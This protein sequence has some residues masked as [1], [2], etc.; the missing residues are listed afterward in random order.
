LGPPA[1][2]ECCLD[3]LGAR[4]GCGRRETDEQHTDFGTIIRD[5]LSGQY[6]YPVGIVAFSAIEGCSRDA[7]SEV[8]DEL[9][10]RAADAEITPPCG[11]S[12][13]RMLPSPLPSN[14]HFHYAE[15]LEHG[16]P[17]PAERISRATTRHD[18]IADYLTRERD[19]AETIDRLIRILDRD[20][21]REAIAEVLVDARVQPRPR[22]EPRRLTDE[23]RRLRRHR[24]VM[25]RPPRPLLG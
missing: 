22:T 9:A 17:R 20:S 1:E 4:A 6:A 3:D 7:T 5:L 11:P 13:K 16:A 2:P 25:R 10:E 19:A 23:L 12:S 24:L 15:L 21:L 14:S 18:G 8:A